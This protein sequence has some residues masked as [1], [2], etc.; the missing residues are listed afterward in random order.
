MFVRDDKGVEVWCCGEGDGGV[1]LLDI[2]EVL[3]DSHCRGLEVGMQWRLVCLWVGVL[4]VLI[5]VI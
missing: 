2:G 3:E 1:R 5:E 4:R